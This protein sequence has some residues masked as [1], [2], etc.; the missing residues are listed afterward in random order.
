[1][2]RHP[3]RWLLLFVGLVGSSAIWI[4]QHR[5]PTTA[6]VGTITFPEE[7]DP[8]LLFAARLPAGNYQLEQLNGTIRKTE[9]LLNFEHILN[10]QGTLDSDD[11]FAR[12]F[13]WE[14]GVAPAEQHFIFNLPLSL[15]VNAKGDLMPVHPRKYRFSAYR[16]RNR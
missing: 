8:Q 9:S 14:R 3:W 1:M 5:M 16:K 2:S 12:T 10:H 4:D 7:S 6:N 11:H 15:Q 13:R